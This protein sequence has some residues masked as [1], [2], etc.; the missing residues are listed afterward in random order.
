[1]IIQDY[2][3]LKDMYVIFFTVLIIHS[4][5]TQEKAI[6]VTGPVNNTPDKQSI[7]PELPSVEDCGYVPDVSDFD[8]WSLIFEDQFDSN[9]SNWTPWIGGAFNQE[10][11]YYRPENL[12]A[13][14]GYLFIRGER[15]NVVGRTNPHDATSKSFGFA[16]GRIESKQEFGP[17]DTVGK[18]SV[19]F[20]ARLRLIEGHGIWPTWWSYNDPWPTKGEI[21]ILEA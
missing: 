7:D 15:T 6:P 13:E 10:L 16:S 20:S 12:F 11:Q 17:E 4:C 1:M 14:D 21:D 9:L 8:G 5:S 19:R 18:E 3:V 2:R